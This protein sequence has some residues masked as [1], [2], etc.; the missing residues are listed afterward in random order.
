[1]IP[2][3]K[4]F[5]PPIEAFI[6][7]FKVSFE[8]QWFT[9]HGEL[10]LEFEKKMAEY[11]NSPYFLLV[12]NGT[13]ALQIA[14]K[15]LHLKDEIITTPFSYVAT[16]S[17]IVWE[18]CT[19]VF[20]DIDPKSL[21]IDPSK[22]EEKITS[23]TTGIL[24]TNVFGYPCDYEA[25]QRIADKHGLKVI[26]D[27]AHGFGSEFN[28]KHL[29]NYGDISTMSFHATKLFHSIEGGGI[30]CKDEKTYKKLMLLR[31]FGHTSPSSFDGVGIN[32]KMN[33][34]CAA[35]GLTNFPY[36]Q[37]V[38]SKRKEQWQIYFDSIDD[39]IDKMNYNLSNIKFNYAYFPLL[40][41]DEQT[42]LKL[43]E[44]L[45]EHEITTR[46]YFYPSLNHLNYVNNSSCPVSEDISSR[47]LCLPL[48]YDL[49]KKEQ[50]NISNLINK[51]V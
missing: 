40:L 45:A 36:I 4:P 34:A 35:M 50:L 49:T 25:I 18:N 46:R 3:T 44:Y 15:A 20:A 17:A 24:A 14:I 48:F 32:G 11:L 16:T 41:K 31:N 38:L 23:K 30:S 33:E 19:P 43:Q 6:E 10:V 8:K 27:N 39:S 28:G 13:I 47:I 1:M 42:T 12:T 51:I 5:T 26:Y 22:I 9:N 2:Q 29:N 21:N 37:E 7:K